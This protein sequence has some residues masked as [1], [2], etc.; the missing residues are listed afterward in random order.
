MHLE[1]ILCL[2]NA[3]IGTTLRND[4]VA[5]TP[6]YLQRITCIGVEKRLIDCPRVNAKLKYDWGCPNKVQVHC[7]NNCMF[8]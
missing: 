2:N 3:S 6:A 1:L 7:D 8:D 4:S 5:I